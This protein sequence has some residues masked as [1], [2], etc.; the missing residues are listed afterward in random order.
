MQ[1]T[2]GGEKDALDKIRH[3]LQE[4]KL[5]EAQ[6]V[7]CIDKLREHGVHTVEQLAAFPV[8]HIGDLGLKPKARSVLKAVI[9]KLNRESHYTFH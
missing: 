5:T 3:L 2:V 7:Q 4:E 8:A 6:I 9:P 1:N